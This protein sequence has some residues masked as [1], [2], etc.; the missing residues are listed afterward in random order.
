MFIVLVLLFFC[1]V[2]AHGGFDDDK[3]GGFSRS[4][5]GSQ[6]DDYDYVIVGGGAGG[7]GAAY[8]LSKGLKRA[9]RPVS[10]AVIEKNNYLGG[11]AYDVDLKMPAPNRYD[12][13]FGP[14][15]RGGVGALRTTQ[16]AMGLKRRL[17][18]QLNLTMY[19]TPFR[20]YVNMRGVRRLCRDPIA[21]AF[22]KATVGEFGTWYR[23][24]SMA[25]KYE[26]IANITAL[27]GDFVRDPSGAYSYGDFCNN[28]APYVDVVNDNS[29][30]FRGF[31]GLTANAVGSPSDAAWLYVLNKV[32]HL[33]GEADMDANNN[34]AFGYGGEHPF[35]GVT[36]ETGGTSPAC[37]GKRQNNLDWKTFLETELRTPSMP[38][39][40]QN[41]SA[42][43]LDDNVGF[44]GDFD[45][46]FSARSYLEYNV[47]EWNTNAF[48]GYLPGAESSLQDAM[49]AE[50]IKN[51]VKFFTNERV[52]TVDKTLQ[53]G[54]RY[55]IATSKRTVR[56]RKFALLN[57]PP[58]Y[59]FERM[60][61]DPI[62]EYDGVDLG[63]DIIDRLRNVREVKVPQPTRAIK[64][65]AQWE[66]G[67]RAWWWDLFDNKNGNY[68]MRQY[69]SSGC[70][71]RIEMADTPK[72]RCTNEVTVVYS[73][74]QCRR[75]WQ[76]YAEEAERT[77][78]YTT[79]GNVIVQ[80]MKAAFPELASKITTRPVFIKY[81]MF[82]SAWHIGK[83]SY[84]DIGSEQLADKASAPLGSIERVG[85]IGEAYFTRRSGWIEGALRSAKRVVDRIASLDGFALSQTAVFDDL[86]DFFRDA[87]SNV[88]DS[89]SVDAN[90]DASAMG[91]M[92]P[93]FPVAHRN[94]LLMSQNERWGPFGDYSNPAYQADSCRPKL[95]GIKV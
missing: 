25:K 10:I 90:G 86:F 26:K 95:Y 94:P 68:S 50:C 48:N 58:F 29:A 1:S 18:A 60:D 46:G 33:T 16:L 35:T 70:A 85:L 81:K 74:R 13:S 52:K 51:G 83:M 78:D 3:D 71:S 76:A 38:A 14:K 34:W 37:P 39:L 24:D 82:N 80:E 43:M 20:N 17:I 62:V 69:G 6:V 55:I 92:P 49:V 45:N 11:N 54:A 32:P 8:W 19:F 63:G 72:H 41:Y 2:A 59:L 15:L 42:F 22:E 5:G 57:L 36:C 64:I 21:K 89:S 93:A 40:N 7:I 84:D 27:A 44:T 4:S 77:G 30:V 23:Y 66:P 61:Q 31:S 47:F 9:N 88:G 87:D 65:V 56:A 73:D 53:Q 28:A 67:K 75:K 91:Y 79:F 12:G